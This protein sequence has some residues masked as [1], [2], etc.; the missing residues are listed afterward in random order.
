[1]KQHNDNSST[2][3]QDKGVTHAHQKHMWM[4]AAC[5]GLP[6]VGFL[7]VGAL[8]ISSSALDTLITLICPLGMVIM[9]YSIMRN[10]VGEEHG[11]SCCQT[12][13]NESQ[14]SETMDLPLHAETPLMEKT[15]STKPPLASGSFKA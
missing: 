10:R 6:V 11:D 1:M 9:M 8:G 7:V 15:D 13:E 14:V 3:N 5:C 2:S 4:M 12:A